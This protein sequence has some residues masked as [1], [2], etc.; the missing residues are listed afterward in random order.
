MA[1]A[2]DG[3]GVLRGCLGVGLAIFAG[4]GSIALTIFLLLAFCVFTAVFTLRSHKW[5]K[6]FIITH[7]IR[8][9]R[10][11][12]DDSKG[13]FQS[14][15]NDDHYGVATFVSGTVRYVLDGELMLTG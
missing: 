10:S 12:G 3:T 11:F 1:E 4:F 8:K 15:P 7:L 13:R 6:L 14:L 2:G 5:D 9:M